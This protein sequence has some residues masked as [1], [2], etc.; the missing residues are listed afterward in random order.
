MSAS[1]YFFF[2]FNCRAKYERK[3]F[4]SIT[5]MVTTLLLLL[6]LH[7]FTTLFYLLKLKV[8]IHFF[9]LMLIIKFKLLTNAKVYAKRIAIRVM[10]KKIL[11]T[12]MLM[13]NLQVKQLTCEK[14]I[15]LRPIIIFNKKN[16]S[17]E[18]MKK[19]N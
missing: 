2:Q 16:C 11:L 7:C 14:C 17:K 6:A 9:F 10:K 18:Q 3:Q 15:T 19:K 4:S 12:W 13:S 8:K 5:Q 1:F